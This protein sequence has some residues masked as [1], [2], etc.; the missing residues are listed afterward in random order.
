MTP[1][2]RRL[3][4]LLLA[5]GAVLWIP[6]HGL[7]GAASGSMSCTPDTSLSTR[8]AVV[9]FVEERTDPGELFAGEDPADVVAVTK[10]VTCRR[11]KEQFEAH[12]D[13]DGLDAEH[14][15]MYFELGDRYLVLVTA[16]PGQFE[17]PIV[18]TDT[19]GQSTAG[20]ILGQ[21]PSAILV[22]D[23]SF[24]QIEAFL[25]PG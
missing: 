6:L 22:Y 18:V 17:G 12:F 8:D 5:L 4:G 2:V 24:N 13:L 7:E 19:T 23:D 20:I 21:P 15:A 1:M 11:L 14:V 3:G 25:F 16:R 9:R 10:Q